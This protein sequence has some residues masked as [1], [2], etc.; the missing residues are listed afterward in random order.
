MALDGRRGAR[1]LADVALVELREAIISGELAPG[2]P[3]RLQDQ[4]D[5]L[6]MS[7]VP[8]REALR[9]LE[10]SGLVD[11]T[12]HR[13]AQ[14]A[15]MSARDLEETYTVRLE[16]ESMAVRLAAER[17][18]EQDREHLLN[19]LDRYAKAS[20]RGDGAARDLHGEVHM[21]LYRL[22]GSKWLLR[23]L[24]MLWDNSERYRRLALPRRGSAEERVAEHRRIVE[25]CAAADPAKAEEELRSHLRHTFEVAI[26]TLK[27]NEER[28]A[29]HPAPAS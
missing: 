29:A 9:F 13:G 6:S 5:R 21:A 16:L 10:R 1:T 26:A 20:R 17:M 24:P 7:S 11:R 3:V 19:L 22:S 23:L 25:A 14:V 15:E 27:E 18:T 8:I 2:S 12:P 4:V 28:Q